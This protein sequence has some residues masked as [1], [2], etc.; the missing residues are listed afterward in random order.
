VPERRGAGRL[1]EACTLSLSMHVL[2]AAWKTAFFYLFLL[3]LMRLTGKREI[4]ALNAIDLVGFIMISEAALI[5]IADTQIPFLVGVT[6]VL[7]LGALMWAM[8]YLS[9]KS[10]RVRE[11]VEGT[12]SVLVAH[13]RLQEGQLRRLRYN[14][15][16]LMAEMRAK[17][18]SSLSDVEFAVLETTGK[19]SIIPRAGARPVTPDDLARLQVAPVDPVQALPTP[20]LPATVVLDGQVDEDALRRAGKDRVWL[21]DELRRQGL[22]GPEHILVASLDAQGTLTAQAREARLADRAQGGSARG[23]QEGQP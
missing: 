5:S 16:D 7:L 22:P 8:S 10:T 12:P 23:Q 9:L 19:L 11:L 18:I 21:E 13:G 1:R 17:N 2:D 15:S 20:E 4:G 6:P 3:A 14:L